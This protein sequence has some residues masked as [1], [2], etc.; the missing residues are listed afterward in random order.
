MAWAISGCLAATFALGAA[1]L[2]IKGFE[3]HSKY[4]EGLIPSPHFAVHGSG[5]VQLELF[6][7]LY[8]GMTGLHAAHMIAGLIAVSWLWRLH[9]RGRLNPAH[10]GPIAVVVAGLMISTQ[11]AIELRRFWELIEEI[12]NAVVFLLVGLEMLLIPY[13]LHH[14]AAGG[15]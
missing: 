2:A 4:A 9:A 10:A 5:G 1:F 14:L 7:V 8:F 12:L 6:L 15:E 3:Y 13:I 11:C